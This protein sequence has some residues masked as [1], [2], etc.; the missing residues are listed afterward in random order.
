MEVVVNGGDRA[1]EEHAVKL[2]IIIVNFN[3]KHFFD[4]C[5]RSLVEHVP[6]EHEVIVVDNAST[7]GSVDY[8]RR[9][10]P[11]I[12][13]IKSNSNLGFAGGNNLAASYAKGDFLLLL[14]NDTILLND[15]TTALVLMERDVSIGI[16]GAR[17]LGENGEYRHSTGYF[18]EPWRLVRL[19]WL[20]RKDNGFGDGVFPK[21]DAK[22]YVDWVE[23]SFLLTP[24][25]LWREI[26]GLDESYFMYI[27]DIDYA[28]RV[29][30]SG[31]QVVFFSG[32]S[33]KHF[34]GYGQSRV[35]MLYDGFR[36]FHR[37][38]SSWP[39]RMLV[40]ITLDVG[41]LVRAFVY[42]LRSIADKQERERAVLC[43]KALR[44][45]R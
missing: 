34:G 41:L 8:L 25:S 45:Q 43:I 10:Y 3:G 19:S 29:V 21:N 18:P 39:K 23:G 6:F 2:S 1:D 17:M 40:N 27:E 5:L 13:L 9:A 24:A 44:R 7:D 33:Y 36:R 31:K 42:M 26:G 16:L 11:E 32:V 20:Y 35:G 28:K 14:N 15:I 30:D 38:H 37:A 22:Q 4:A 12:R